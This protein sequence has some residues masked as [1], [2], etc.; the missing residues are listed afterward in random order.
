MQIVSSRN[1]LHGISNPVFFRGGN[2]INL[3]SAELA[4][5]L[6][7][8]KSVHT[9]SDLAMLVY[10]YHVIVLK[11]YKRFSYKQTKKKKKMLVRTMLF[12]ESQ[13]VFYLSSSR[14]V[15]GPTVFLSER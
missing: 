5:R 4:K 9:E 13:P 8:V 7:K 15:I 1:N 14:T 10:T 12:R 11:P 6:V 3:S 2:I